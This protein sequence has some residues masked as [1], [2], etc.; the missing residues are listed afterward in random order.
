MAG[1]RQVW[2]LLLF[3]ILSIIG[4]AVYLAHVVPR[5]TATAV[6]LIGS[7]KDKTGLSA[8][9]ADLTYDAGA[10]DSQLEILK[11][12]GLAQTVINDL[13]LEAN[14]IPKQAAEPHRSYCRTGQVEA[15]SRGSSRPRRHPTAPTLPHRRSER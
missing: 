2:V 13:K 11:S 10:I 3:C 9:I 1:R 15:A 14:S 12:E 8:S 7:A 4:G 5:Y 6:V